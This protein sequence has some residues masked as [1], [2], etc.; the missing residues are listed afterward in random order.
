[1]LNEKTLQYA[2]LFLT[3]FVLSLFFTPL[4][5]IFAIKCGL[6]S[7]PRVDRW[8]K[9]PTAL[10]GGAGI[11]VAF[12][13]PACLLNIW[14]KDVL[15]L[16]FGATILFCVGLADD[17]FHF[18]PYV[19]LFAQIIAGC[20]AIFFGI[21]I[22]L[23]YSIS[24]LSIPLTLIWIV[25]VTNSF[26]LLD[27]IDGLAG[28]IAAI[29]SLL[30]FFS[31]LVFSNNA[32]GIYGL[33]LS[34]AALGF[35]P[36][37][38]NPAKIFMGDSGSM[39]LGFS[40]AVISISRTTRHISNLLI[41]M[42]IPVLILSVPI[43]DTIFVMFLRRFQGRKI[44]EGGKDHTSHHLVILG[45]SQR[46]TVLLLYLIS[47]IFG[48]IAI[49]YSKLNVFVIS[50]IAGIAIIILV[51]FGFFLNEE[52]SRNGNAKKRVNKEDGG[53]TILNSVFMYKRR[54]VEVLLDF[55]II[56][57][58]YYAAYFLRFEGALLTSNLNLVNESIGWII[59]IKMTMFFS[60]GLYRGVW[61]YISI[62]DLLTIF[63]VVSVSSIASVMF[64]TFRFR[65]HEYSRAVFFIDWIL[66]LFLVSGVRV[67]FRLLGEF[68]SRAREK[69]DNVL[70][71]GA[72]DTG[73]MVI[74][75]I[76][77]NKDLNLNPIGFIDDNPAKL[78]NKIQGITVLGTREEIRGVIGEYGIKEVLIAVPN[79]DIVELGEIARI[80]KECGIK[81]R[82]IRGILDKEDRADV[83]RNQ[84][85]KDTR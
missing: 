81:Y 44:F 78:G 48:S 31:S 34:G 11:Y 5:R 4:V 38:F 8:H 18:K 74:R 23:P 13:I 29:A 70:I 72:G 9:N 3:S 32:L 75:E 56:C 60:L 2:T 84:D 77:R 85:S 62:S 71:F 51:F 20:I 25:G 7:F 45:I 68:F 33:I 36:Y 79:I 63:K 37:N 21:S 69:G 46:K 73:E 76:K 67:L 16:F 49:L 12:L 30:L 47:I 82:K 58:A 54:I 64:L 39:F 66:L 52:A 17:K 59:L 15:G 61:R 27:N 19:K 43:F 6:I 14:D 65:F 40:L 41:T 26:N 24:F 42:L 35:L 83:G 1:M 28:G 57:I 55:M 10:L 50:V 80:C 53:K 22:S